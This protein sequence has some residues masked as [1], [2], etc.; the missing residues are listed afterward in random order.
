MGENSDSE[1][2]TMLDLL[3]AACGAPEQVRGWAE[4]HGMPHG[5]WTVDGLI[6]AVEKDHQEAADVN[7]PGLNFKRATGLT[8]EEARSGYTTYEA[9]AHGVRYRLVGKGY[10]RERRYYAYRDVG[11]RLVPAA[12]GGAHRTLATAKV[13]AERDLADVLRDREASR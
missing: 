12:R 7:V 8:G 10:G 5:S 11:T 4:R 9:E 13:Q 2:R 3:D 1:K 6:A